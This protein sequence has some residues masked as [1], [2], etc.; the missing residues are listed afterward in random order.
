[1]TLIERLQERGLLLDQDIAVIVWTL[2]SIGAW[3]TTEA[4]VGRVYEN[5]TQDAQDAGGF[6]DYDPKYDLLVGWET[7]SEWCL[8][9]FTNSNAEFSPCSELNGIKV[10]CINMLSPH[11]RVLIGHTAIF[12]DLASSTLHALNNRLH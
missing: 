7:S 9:R 6:Q 5:I 4:I 8:H 12:V 10:D 3:R 2:D 1:M 11:R